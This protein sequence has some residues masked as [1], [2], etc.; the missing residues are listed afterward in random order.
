MSDL[1]ETMARAIFKDDSH[2]IKG[3]LRWGELYE[4]DKRPWRDTARAALAAIEAA[5]YRV[6]PVER[7]YHV[8]GTTVG[9]HIDECAKCGQDIRSGIHRM[10]R[11]QGA[12]DDG[13]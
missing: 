10:L 9:K 3:G 11:A 2:K 1:I 8:A 5:G 12:R 13:R 4:H 7:H 6:V